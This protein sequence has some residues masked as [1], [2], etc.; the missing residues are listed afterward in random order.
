MKPFAV[1][2]ELDPKK[3]EIW[4]FHDDIQVLSEWYS[5]PKGALQISENHSQMKTHKSFSFEKMEGGGEGV[6]EESVRIRLSIF[7]NSKL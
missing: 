1:A 3:R 5:F 7:F 4:I 6:E 2:W